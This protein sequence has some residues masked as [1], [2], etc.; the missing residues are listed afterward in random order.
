[1]KIKSIKIENFRSHKDSTINLRDYNLITGPNSSG[2]SSIFYALLCFYNYKGIKFNEDKDRS[3][4]SRDQPSRVTVTYE[5]NQN[6]LG[7]KNLFNLD[8]NQNELSINYDL[9]ENKYKL[10]GKA[11]IVKSTFTKFFEKTNIIFIPAIPDSSEAFKLTGPSIMRDALTEILKTIWEQ[12]PESKKV[13]ETL[14]QLL[15][16]LNQSKTNAGISPSQITDKINESIKNVNLKLSFQTKTIDYTTLISNIY[17]VGV[18]DT[19]LSGDIDPSTISTGQMKFLFYNLIRV[20]KDLKQST[21]VDDS[22][23]QL[24]FLIFEEPEA[25]LHPSN[26]LSLGETMRSLASSEGW[27]FAIS[28]HSPFFISKEIENMQ[29]II[30]IERDKSGVSKIFQINEEQWKDLKKNEDFIAFLEK[31]ENDPE[32]SI[33]LDL[34]GKIEQIIKT[35]ENGLD[36]FSYNLY[37]NSERS[38]LFLSDKVIICEGISDKLLVDYIIKLM[39]E[40]FISEIYVMESSGKYDIVRYMKILNHFGIKHCI[41]YDTDSNKKQNKNLAINVNPYIEESIE[42]YS[43]FF[44]GSICFNPNLEEE[45]MFFDSNGDK[46]SNNEKAL[47]ILSGIKTGQ[48]PNFNNINEKV[49]N[50][51]QKLYES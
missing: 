36:E 33:N 45:N 15:S 50:L 7:I 48:L 11:D 47:Y 28:T 23:N 40:K 43:N 41:I 17:T 24:H 13:N 44:V 51:V 38:R 16:S 29:D 8:T 20:L 34:R 25:F 35:Y 12:S 32:L 6:D 3:K 49:A 9:N 18:S 1:M 4:F 14:G 26:Q 19:K 21:M 10:E 2:K 39:G 30:R 42:K 31:L 46:L 22:G 5:L 27:Q 37:L